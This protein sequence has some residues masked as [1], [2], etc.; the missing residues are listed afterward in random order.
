MLRGSTK[1]IEALEKAVEDMQ[2]KIDRLFQ[3]VSYSIT[4]SRD[5]SIDY[6]EYRETK[7][8]YP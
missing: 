5:I 6:D 7:D 8:P 2:K 4:K 3:I 1:R